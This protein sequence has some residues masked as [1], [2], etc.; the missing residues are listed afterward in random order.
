[1]KKYK[2]SRLIVS[3]A[4][5]GSMAF[6]N[7]SFAASD[8]GINRGQSEMTRVEDSRNQTI[9]AFDVNSGTKKRSNRKSKA[10]RGPKSGRSVSA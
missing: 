1:M 2:R 3:V 7:M 6:T 8:T 10:S 9:T 4:L 5:L